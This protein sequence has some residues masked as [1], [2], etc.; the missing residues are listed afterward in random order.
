MNKYVL[1]HRDTDG[2]FAAVVAYAVLGD[3]AEYISVQYNEPFPDIYLDSDTELYILDFSYSRELLDDIYSKVNKL[4]VLDHHK[5]AE[6][7]LKNTPYAIFDM[8]K[9]GSTLAWEYFIPDSPMPKIYELVEDRDLFK[10]EM[11]ETDLVVEGLRLYDLTDIPKLYSLLENPYQFLNKVID[12]GEVLLKVRQNKISKIV[13]S[14]NL[15]FTEFKGK[16]AVILNNIDL[17]S[18]ISKEMFD[19]YPGTDI[20][21]GWSNIGTKI[22]FSLRSNKLKRNVDVSKICSKYGGGGHRNAAGFNLPF[23]EGVEL[24]DSLLNR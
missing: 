18:D 24:I 10:Y 23:K 9:C 20:V 3:T 2:A 4:V 16:S 22:I 11:D 8:D 12:D 14:T 1:Y 7:E 5:T 13:N 6:S 19:V 15:I 17:I 21:I